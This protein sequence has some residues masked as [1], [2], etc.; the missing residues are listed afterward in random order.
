MQTILNMLGFGCKMDTIE[1]LKKE[2]ARLLKQSQICYMAIMAAIGESVAGHDDRTK[3]K[4]MYDILSIAK[5]ELYA[6]MK[7][8]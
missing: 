5:E 6:T 8:E 3:V 1:F 4:L 2:N 7:E